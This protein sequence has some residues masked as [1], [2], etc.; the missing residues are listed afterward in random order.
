MTAF[1]RALWILVACVAGFVGAMIYDWL[2][3][4]AG[5][6]EELRSRRFVLVGTD[7]EIRAVLGH[8]PW[9]S[10]AGVEP[11]TEYDAVGLAVY[12]KGGEARVQLCTLGPGSWVRLR[13]NGGM[14]AF[15][16]STNG[17]GMGLFSPESQLRFGLGMQLPGNG[18]VTVL[19]LQSR[20]RFGMGMPP[21]AG[22]SMSLQDEEGEVVWRA[23]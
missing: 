20:Q 5:T 21:H 15:G 4:E 10:R 8:I 12:D 11:V 1:A 19:D 9:R 22:I 18:G 6:A 14:S 23:P 7:G 17:A 3:E 16:A 13:H 2:S